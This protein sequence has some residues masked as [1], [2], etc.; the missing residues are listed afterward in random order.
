MGLKLDIKY[1]T[2][3]FSHETRP[4][5][6]RCVL[7][8]FVAGT[9]RSTFLEDARECFLEINN[10]FWRYFAMCWVVEDIIYDHVCTMLLQVRL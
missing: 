3:R 7:S 6:K 5:C 9:L 10:A 4:C 2:G 1:D 8:G